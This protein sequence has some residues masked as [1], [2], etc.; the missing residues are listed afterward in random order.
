[1]RIIAEG[2]LATLLEVEQVIEWLESKRIKLGGRVRKYESNKN[3]KLCSDIF[4]E[5]RWLLR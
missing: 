1:M 5:P 4:L 3:K 2:R